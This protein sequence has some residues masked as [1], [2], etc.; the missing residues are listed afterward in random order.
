LKGNLE[1][2]A[3]EYAKAL[4][5]QPKYAQAHFN[6]GNVLALQRRF[7]EAKPHFLEALRL[8]PD[9]A[10]A[11]IHLA[12]L[13][14]IQGRAEEAIPHCRAGLA[15]KPNAAEAYYCLANAQVLQSKPDLAKTHYL[16]ALRLKPDYAEAHSKF[17]ELLLLEGRPA[18][19]MPHLGAAADL[20]PDNEEFQ[21]ALGGAL[22]LG[23]IT[24]D[25]DEPQQ[26]ST[27]IANRCDDYIGPEGRTVFA[28]SPTL[29]LV[30]A[31]RAR[32]LQREPRLVALDVSTWIEA[33]KILPKNL[34]LTVLHQAFRADI[35]AQH[36][37]VR[38]EH[39]DRVVDH[40][41]EQ[42]AKPFV[43]LQQREV[44][45]RRDRAQRFRV[46]QFLRHAAPEATKSQTSKNNSGNGN[47]PHTIL[48]VAGASLLRSDGP[49]F[50]S[51]P[52]SV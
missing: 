40:I 14:V 49:S 20:Q 6:M 44:R 46:L 23:Q 25:L 11:H 41:P 34:L 3:D 28:K 37:T 15:T 2:A 27:L 22:A 35:P 33:G 13:L 45:T 42:Q 36:P 12:N 1:G 47:S 16:T 24:D 39:D 9:Y 30:A 5:L 43:V 21:Y 19:A 8:D 31:L 38:I 17:G 50:T 26:Y 7:D 48:S 51:T 52:T 4:E 29:V 32:P 10:D 18:E